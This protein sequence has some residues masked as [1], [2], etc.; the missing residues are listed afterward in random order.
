[1]YNGF[2]KHRKFVMGIAILLIVFL[3]TSFRFPF[4]LHYIRRLGYVQVDTF[5]MLSGY[6]LYYSLSKTTDLYGYIKKRWLRIYPSYFLF[7]I[8]FLIYKVNVTSIVFSNA[9]GIVT[10]LSYWAC[11]KYAFSWFGE[12]IMLFYIIA[13]F[14]Y[15]IVKHSKRKWHIILASVILVIPF[16]TNGRFMLPVSR[17]ISFTT[18]FIF[19]DYYNARLF[20]HKELQ[21]KN[22][23]GFV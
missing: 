10:G 18:G 3:H 12:T 5:M 14:L 11:Q 23:L 20:M 17:I 1:M 21:E 13:P 2:N 22:Y 19:A 9:V 7:A 15:A 4:I 6:G 16:V 8:I